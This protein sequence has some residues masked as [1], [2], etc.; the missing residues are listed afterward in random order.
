MPPGWGVSPEIDARLMITP[1]FPRAIIPGATRFTRR[2]ADLRL[3]C[4]ILW[5]C[6][7]VAS[8]AGPFWRLVA[9][10]L[11]RI[12]IGP[13]ALGL[14]HRALQLLPS[15]DVAGEREH[16]SGEAGELPRGLLHPREL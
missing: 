15:P 9:L 8:S 2:K 13:S 4:T 6:S 11:T 5:S 10:L 12:P 3:I 1:P 16:L 14:P 7:S